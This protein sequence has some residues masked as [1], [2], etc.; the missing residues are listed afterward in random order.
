MALD[1][2]TLPNVIADVGATLR[3]VLRDQIADLAPEGR[4]VFDSPAEVEV[5][6]E[7]RLG[8]FLYQVLETPQ[9]RNQPPESDGLSGARRYQTVDLFYLVTPYTQQMEDGHRLLGRVMRVFF[10][11]A[12][13][14][15]SIL[16]GSLADIGQPLRILL[17]P[18]TPEEINRVWGLFPNKPYR[19]SIAYQVTPVKVFGGPTGLA[20]RV[21]AREL[22]YVQL[23]VEKG[24]G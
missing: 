23:I 14:Q 19:L 2:A 5:T 9:M 12:V 3:Q 4:V 17:H 11:H 21:I 6:T 18:L 13:L 22:E 24:G 1:D 15:G 16:Q 20:G 8:L 7:P 10:E